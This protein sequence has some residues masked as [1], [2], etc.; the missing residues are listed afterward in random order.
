MNRRSECKRVL[1]EVKNS[2]L[3]SIV[4]RSEI[5][6]KVIVS[7]VR[8]ASYMFIRIFP[9]T[10]VT[11]ET[12]LSVCYQGFSKKHSEIVSNHTLCIGRRNTLFYIEETKSD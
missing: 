7:S 12:K 5:D 2:Y 3:R 6:V 9:D 11:N 8:T 10:A 1:C 4:V